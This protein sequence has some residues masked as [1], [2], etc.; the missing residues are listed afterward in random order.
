MSVD[1]AQWGVAICKDNNYD[2]EL[3]LNTFRTTG[4]RALV[5]ILVR[6]GVLVR[7]ESCVTRTVQSQKSNVEGYFDEKDF[8]KEVF[9]YQVVSSFPPT[10]IASKGLS[11][12]S[13]REL[14]PEEEKLET[15]KRINNHIAW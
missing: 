15:I 3:F 5:D 4:T 12:R 9:Y 10:S 11:L 1:R 8:G 6:D 2:A 13:D 7:D 14:T